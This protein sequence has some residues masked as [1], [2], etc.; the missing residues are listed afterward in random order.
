MG[1][2]VGKNNEG[3]DVG[4]GVPAYCDHPGCNEEIDRGLG[5][6]CGSEPDGGDDGCGR[7]FCGKHMLAYQHCAKCVAGEDPFPAKAD[8]PQWLDWKLTD[9]S[10]AKW[11]EA[12]P[13]AVATAEAALRK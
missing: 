1:W 7:F 6:I 10:W 2:S 4:Y 8:H 5:Y 13:E 12:N 3:R 11:R 9:D